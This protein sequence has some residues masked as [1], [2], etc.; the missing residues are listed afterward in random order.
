MIRVFRQ[1]MVSLCQHSVLKDGCTMNDIALAGYQ[2]SYN[3]FN[4]LVSEIIACITRQFIRDR[5]SVV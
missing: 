2:I 4:K 3:K 1:I 5:K